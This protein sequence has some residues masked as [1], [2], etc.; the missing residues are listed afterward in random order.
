MPVGL[1]AGAFE[2]G[3]LGDEAVLEAFVRALPGWRL[4]VTTADRAA[5]ARHGCEVVDA[6]RTADTARWA[7][8]AEAVVVGGSSPFSI[9]DRRSGVHGRSPLVTTA[10]LVTAASVLARP[11]AMVGVGTCRLPGVTARALARS[12]VRHTDLLVLRDEASVDELVR[13]GVPTPVRVGADPTWTLVAGSEPGRP[14]PAQRPSVII[15]PS[16]SAAGAAGV[17]AL[18]ASLADTVSRLSASGAHV[19]LQPWHVAEPAGTGDD[20]A[21]IDAVLSAAGRAGSRRAEVLP[22]PGSLPDAAS[23]MAGAGAVV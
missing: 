13:A 16:R 21:V 7:A 22:T 14:E 1:L 11:V 19:L 3:S 20:L 4:A 10:A 17:H 2:P 6:H 5:A 15:A 18:V 12:I 23:S 8:R 9:A